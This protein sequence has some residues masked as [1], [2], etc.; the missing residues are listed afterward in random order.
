VPITK[1][2]N[3]NIFQLFHCQQTQSL[4]ITL[5][6]NSIRLFFIVFSLTLFYDNKFVKKK[7]KQIFLILSM[8]SKNVVFRKSVLFTALLEDISFMRKLQILFILT[9]HFEGLA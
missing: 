5:Y 7:L 2:K 3:T 1:Q 6:F 8:Y 4:L 9:E